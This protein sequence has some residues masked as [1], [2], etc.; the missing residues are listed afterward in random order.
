MLRA[1]AEMCPHPP[2]KTLV[3]LGAPHQGIYGMP[4]CSKTELAFCQ[5]V[6]KS[7]SIGAYLPWVQGMLLA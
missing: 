6:W 5:M 2:M 7:L 1:L 4:R 3:T